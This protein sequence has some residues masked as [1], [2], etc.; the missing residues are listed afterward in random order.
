MM[1]NFDMGNSG[2]GNGASN[3]TL[4]GN[5]IH[6]VTFNGV[7]YS[8]SKDKKWE[9]MRI[10]FN[11]KSGGYFSDTTFG[12]QKDSMERK[13]TQYGTN[14][15][16]YDNLMMKIKHLLTAV[17]PKLLEQMMEGEIKF[18]PT[19]KNNIFKQ[20]VEFISEQLKSYEGTPTKIKLVKNNKGEACF[21]PFF[22]GLSQ[23]DVVYMRTNFIGM[24]LS[25]TPKETELMNTQA[26]AKPTVMAD[27]NT[28]M[29][30]NNSEG[31]DI[32]NTDF[33]SDLNLSL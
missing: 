1:M 22:A 32:L 21:P 5:K 19:N 28:S 3:F 2:Y 33:T 23:D 17:A 4:E 25:F 30:L 14:P 9:F 24:N 18:T 16:Q 12:L 29:D 7:E 26:K 31:D 8:Q 27:I 15:S 13:S 6:D 11:G 20:Y 10:K